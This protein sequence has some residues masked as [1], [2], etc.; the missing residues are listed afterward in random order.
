MTR[1]LRVAR[2]TAVK[3]RTQAINAIKALLVN[4]PAE[5]REQLDGLPTTRLVRQAA[6]LDPGQVATPTAACMRAVRSLAERYQQ[7]GAEIQLLTSEL[8]RLTL[9]HAPALRS[10]LG[11]GPEVAAEL[12]VWAGDNPARLVRRPH[13]R[14][15]AA[16]PRWR[17]PRQDPP[18][19]PE[20]GRGPTRQRR[21]APDRDRAASLAPADPRLGRQA[22]CPGQDQEGNPALPQALR[23]P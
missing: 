6:T 9:Q 21:P 1:A 5:L 14:R 3:A 13:P 12:L 7:L 22:H 16:P 15:W 4:A 17:P 10:V 23:R 18:A 11:I 2:Q 8:D 19:P 20:P